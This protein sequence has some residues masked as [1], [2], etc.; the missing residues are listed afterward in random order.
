MSDDTSFSEFCK[1]GFCATSKFVGRYSWKALKLFAKVSYK[2]LCITAEYIDKHLFDIEP[3]NTSSN[4]RDAQ[5]NHSNTPSNTFTQNQNNHLNHLNTFFNVNT[6]NISTSAKNNLSWDPRLNPF[7][8]PDENLIKNNSLNSTNLLNSAESYKNLNIQPKKQ[9][10]KLKKIL[11]NFEKYKRDEEV[12]D[13]FLRELVNTL[14]LGTIDFKRCTFLRDLVESNEEFVFYDRKLYIVSKPVFNQ[15]IDKRYIIKN[16]ERFLLEEIEDVSVLE[17]FFVKKQAKKIEKFRKDSLKRLLD[18]CSHL[19]MNFNS[20]YNSNDYLDNFIAN[21]LIPMKEGAFENIPL[22]CADIPK[23]LEE[24]VSLEFNSSN[25]E[26]ALRRVRKGFCNGFV[27][28][29]GQ[30]YGIYKNR[31]ADLFNKDIPFEK[32]KSKKIDLD[33]FE[34]TYQKIILESIRKKIREYL[35]YYLKESLKKEKNFFPRKKSSVPSHKNGLYFDKKSSKEYIISED[36]GDFA[37]K[38][39]NSY[40]HFN[41]TRIGIRVT[42]VNNKLRISRPFIYNDPSFRHPF[43]P[44]NNSNEKRI[45]LGLANS[46]DYRKNKWGIK[47]DTEEDTA[48]SILT[49]LEK[50]KAILY[51]VPDSW[52]DVYC[53]LHSSSGVKINERKY[54][55]LVKRGALAW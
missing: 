2:A 39:N 18:K 53:S 32:N 12:S 4:T 36:T 21:Y 22:K 37:V 24:K 45:C 38:S 52:S 5:N 11:E 33:S 23:E 8:F 15:A 10:T 27:V 46:E 29:S 34:L 51:T 47:T 7:L 55:E 16:D 19:G 17:E 50:A 41:S 20:N 9:N 13:S 30:I 49:L 31:I 54:K 25:L 28:A 26:K 43:V 44:V 6:S 42:F 35:F 14:R 48:N 3:S 1:R 40:Y